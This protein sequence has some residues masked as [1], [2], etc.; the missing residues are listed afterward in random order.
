[1]SVFFSPWNLDT[2]ASCGKGPWRSR[3]LPIGIPKDHGG[4]EGA[5][6]TRD[7]LTGLP[8]NLKASPVVYQDPYPNGGSYENVNGS[9]NN[10]HQ[11]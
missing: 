5:D 4:Q 10:R 7:S 2:Q 6:Q 8:A 11:R 1:M 9:Y 3:I